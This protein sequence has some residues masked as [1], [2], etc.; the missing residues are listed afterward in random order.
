MVSCLYQL[1]SCIPYDFNLALH[2]SERCLAL[3]HLKHLR[4]QDVVVYDRG[5]YS[6]AMRYVHQQQGVDAV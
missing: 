3:A 5:Y 1:K 4:L 6:Y 2:L